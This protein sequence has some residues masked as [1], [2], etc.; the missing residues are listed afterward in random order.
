MRIMSLAVV[1]KCAHLR[2]CAPL[3]AT[4]GQPCLAYARYTLYLL[5]VVR[6]ADTYAR[7]GACAPTDGRPCLALLGTCET[8]YHFLYHFLRPPAFG[9][10]V[11]GLGTSDLGAPGFAAPDLGAPDLRIPFLPL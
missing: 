8:S 4:T 2:G 6:I 1:R 3:G 7:C 10:G 9:L 11:L 5:T